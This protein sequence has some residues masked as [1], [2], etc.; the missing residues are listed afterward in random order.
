MPR[1]QFG[2]GKCHSTIDQ[3]LFFCQNIR[4]A[5][6]IKPTHHTIAALLDLTKAFDRVWKHKL[7]IKLHDTLNIPGNTL[8]WISDI[9]HHRSIRVKFNK[10]F[11][12]R[13]E[14]GQGI[15]QGSVLGPMLFSRYIAG[16]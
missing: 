3:V 11:S 6:N 2:Y 12:D 7:L 8:A 1:E 4:D 5:Q 9:L 14:R 10:T 16:N 15:P 13:V